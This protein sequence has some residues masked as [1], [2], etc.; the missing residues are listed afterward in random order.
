MSDRWTVDEL[1]SWLR[2]PPCTKCGEPHVLYDCSQRLSWE[3]AAPAN[4]GENEQR[5]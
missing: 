3:V 2:L 4:Q 1:R 5:P